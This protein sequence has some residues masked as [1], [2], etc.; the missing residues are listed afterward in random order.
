VVSDLQHPLVAPS[1]WFWYFVGVPLLRTARGLQF[2]GGA[3]QVGALSGLGSPR[4]VLAGPQ[5]VN[6]NLASSLAVSRIE[7]AALLPGL[8]TYAGALRCRMVRGGI[9]AVPAAVGSAISL[10]LHW[11]QSIALGGVPR[12]LR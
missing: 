10:G 9:A 11:S 4:L 3:G 6:G 2:L 12:A 7:F 5:L 8:I 1:S